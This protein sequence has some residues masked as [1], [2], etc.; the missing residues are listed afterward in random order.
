MATPLVELCRSKRNFIMPITPA[1][2]GRSQLNG[3]RQTH[4]LGDGVMIRKSPRVI[5][6]PSRLI[7]VLRRQMDAG[8][9][10]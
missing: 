7:F 5:S 10:V 6:S 4:H 2:V 8:G 3:Q 1:S 9:L